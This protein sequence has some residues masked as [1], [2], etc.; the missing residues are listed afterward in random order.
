MTKKVSADHR[1]VVMY[2]DFRQVAC[3]FRAAPEVAIPLNFRVADIQLQDK[4]E[5]FTD[6]AGGGRAGHNDERHLDRLEM[7]FA[8]AAMHTAVTETIGRGLE[9]LVNASMRPNRAPEE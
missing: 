9:L 1:A 5:G 2:S 3:F 4:I 6:F 7:L 8:H